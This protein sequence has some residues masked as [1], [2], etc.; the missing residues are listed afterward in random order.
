MNILLGRVGSV[1]ERTGRGDGTVD[2]VLGSR[3][4][5]RS[6]TLSVEQPFAPRPTPGWA[7]S[8]PA[9]YPQ[10]PDPVPAGDEPATGEPV[11]SE[12]TTGRVEAEAEAE[13]EVDPGSDLQVGT[14][15]PNAE[16][17]DVATAAD[18]ADTVDNDVVDGVDQPVAERV[19]RQVAAL[20]GL[21]AL[22]LSEHARRYDEVHAEL[23]AALTEIDG[24]SS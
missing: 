4:E 10:P 6:R 9:G 20:D 12:A 7:R 15:G 16:T 13:I 2:S 23:Q 3:H 24:E 5:L 1:G 8:E 14:V 17:S 19:R 22:P 11:V 18:T 21:A